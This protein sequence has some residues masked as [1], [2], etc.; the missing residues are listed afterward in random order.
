MKRLSDGSRWRLLVIGWLVS[1]SHGG[2]GLAEIHS[3]LEVRFRLDE[4]TGTTANDSSTNTGRN[5]TLTNGAQFISGGRV[6]GAVD[7]DGSNDYVAGPTIGATD[8]ASAVTVAF[9]L[10]T[11]SRAAS[12]ILVSKFLNFSNF[13]TLQFGASG[14]GDQDDI[15]VFISTSA[16]AG[17]VYTTGNVLSDGRK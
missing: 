6:G 13:F 9:W 14:S 5:G 15:A 17:S 11:D 1:F 12:E 4:G 16:T 2:V 8:S 10:N 3:G 7:L